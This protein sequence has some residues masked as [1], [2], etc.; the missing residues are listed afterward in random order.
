MSDKSIAIIKKFIT[1]LYQQVQLEVQNSWRDLTLLNI[2]NLSHNLAQINLDQCP[3]AEINNKGYL[4]FPKGKQVKWLG[5][6]IAIPT[7]LQDYPISNLTLRLVLT[8][9]AQEAK[10]FINGELVQEG[11]LFDSSARVAITSK[12]Q[13]GE[14]YIVAIRLT[15]PNHDIGALMRS[16]LLYEQSY[17]PEHIDPG[18]VADELTVL[19]KYLSEFQPEYLEVLAGELNK[20]DWHNIKDAGRF[21]HD[22]EELR[23]SLLPLG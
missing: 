13:P 2:V 5:Q 1:K 4:V 20:F 14:E 18:L 12:A 11:D 23:E 22:L 8:W 7:A 19:S 9:W 10:I 17:L 16:H 6:K 21:S 3:L 15:S